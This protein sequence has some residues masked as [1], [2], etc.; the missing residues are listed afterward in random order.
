MP[1]GYLARESFEVRECKL[2]LFDLNGALLR[3][4]KTISQATLKALRKCKIDPKKQDN[5]WGDS[6][7]TDFKENSL[8]MCVEIFKDNQARKLQELLNGCDCIR[9]SG[10]YGYKFTK[11]TATKERAIKEVKEKA[12]CV[13]GS[14]DED[15]I[16][17][18][19]AAIHL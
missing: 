14:N 5:S 17:A 19:L 8:K 6:I 2:L 4:D 13:I 18:Y 15:G 7:Y 9:F 12:D 3:S 10:G 11:K 16:A 1:Y